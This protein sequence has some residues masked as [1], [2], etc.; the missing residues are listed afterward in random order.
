MDYPTIQTHLRIADLAGAVSNPGSESR[1]QC[2][3]DGIAIH[4]DEAGPTIVADSETSSQEDALELLD[5]DISHPKIKQA[6]A[7]VMRAA[8]QGSGRPIV[9][10]VGPPGVGKSHL[11]EP[12]ERKLSDIQV[13]TVAIKLSQIGAV[14]FSFKSMYMSL[15]D[16][17]PEPPLPSRRAPILPHDRVSDSG[18]GICRFRSATVRAL[19]RESKKPVV[20]LDECAH[21]LNVNGNEKLIRHGQTLRSFGHDAGAI[22]VMFC[23]YNG[24]PLLKIDRELLRRIKVIH[25]PRYHEEVEADV[26]AYHK[27]V[28]SLGKRLKLDPTKLGKLVLPLMERTVGCVGTTM[29]VFREAVIEPR[30]ACGSF[31][32]K[33]ITRSLPSENYATELKREVLEKEREIAGFL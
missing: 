22:L 12:A 20:L 31:D 3:V 30:S 6:L 16:K 19:N 23:S 10:V 11:V 15:Y 13:P 17:L 21:I 32:Y 4:S 27:V 26:D 8:A 18:R 1:E 5:R 29:N 25:F 24:I 7:E 28:M 14:D 9:M 2:T 33:A